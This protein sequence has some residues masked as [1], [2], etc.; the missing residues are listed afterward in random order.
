MADVR[1][2]RGGDRCAGAQRLGRRSDPP[3]GPVPARRRDRHGDRRCTAGQ[4]R[5]AAQPGCREPAA[6]RRRPGGRC[7]ARPAE[8]RGGATP[9]VDARR[10]ERPGGPGQRHLARCARGGGRVR[11]SRHRQPRRTRPAAVVRRG[12]DHAHRAG[13]GD[14]RAHRCRRGR[15]AR[16]DRGDGSRGAGATP[17]CASGSALLAG[18]RAGRGP[19]ARF[20]VRH[21]LGGRRV[22]RR[23]RRPAVPGDAGGGPRRA[24]RR[25]VDAAVR[26]R[27]RRARRGARGPADDDLRRAFGPR[28]LPGRGDP[29]VLPLPRHVPAAALPDRRD[30]RRVLL[31]GRRRR[32][33]ARRDRR[34]VDLGARLA[35][36]R[37]SRRRGDQP[38]RGARASGCASSRMMIDFDVGQLLPTAVASSGTRAFVSGK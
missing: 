18:G 10:A 3:G 9:V 2:A 5:G 25:V 22:A 11:R 7:P 15:R 19:G 1:I 21:P 26:H 23:A 37:R 30:A 35:P 34:P 13:R 20:G 27:V 24:R 8:H 28:R 32:R 31:R 33:S 6:G 38:A 4:R 17:A 14:R 16:A 29:R 12:H 36:G